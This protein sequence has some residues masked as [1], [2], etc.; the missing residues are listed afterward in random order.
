[1]WVIKTLDLENNLS[2]R[3]EDGAQNPFPM[4]GKEN[5]AGRRALQ[6]EALMLLLLLTSL[7]ATVSDGCSPQ[8]PTPHH[9][10]AKTGT[11]PTLVKLSQGWVPVKTQAV[12]IV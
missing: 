2:A 6:N 5:T 4:S 10:A 3:K 7:M 11:L 9:P 8:P 1:M 12:G